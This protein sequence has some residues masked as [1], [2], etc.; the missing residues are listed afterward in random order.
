MKG[1]KSSMSKVSFDFDSTLDRTEIQRFAR[2][3]IATGHEVYIITSRKDD[4]HAAS[5]GWN[6][7]V[8]L[9]AEELRIPKDHIVFTNMVDKF[10]FMLMRDDLIDIKF[11]LDDDPEELCLINKHT[12]T[13]GVSCWGNNTWK[14][15]CLRVLSNDA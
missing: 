5:P 4:E 1:T 14:Q 10:E 13:V 3:L 7:D 15:K 8:Y 9:V 6:D 12:E 11:H 2:E